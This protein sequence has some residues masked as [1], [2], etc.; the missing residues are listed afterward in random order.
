MISS[1]RG[2][3]ILASVM[4]RRLAAAGAALITEKLRKEGVQLHWSLGEGSF[5]NRGFFPGVN[6]LIAPINVAEKGIMNLMIVAK[7]KGGHSS[8]PPKRNCSH[9]IS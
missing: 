1:Q 8:T 7:A 4:M 9:H 2:L 3:F 6:K 5:V